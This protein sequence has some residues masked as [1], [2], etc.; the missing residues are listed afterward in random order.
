MFIFLTYVII[1]LVLI[2]IFIWIKW[3]VLNCLQSY[4]ALQEVLHARLT[5]PNLFHAILVRGQFHSIRARAV[6]KQLQPRQVVPF[7]SGNETDM[8]SPSLSPSFSVCL[9]VR[10]SYSVGFKYFLLYLRVVPWK[11]NAQ[12]RL[13]PFNFIFKKR[14]DIIVVVLFLLLLLSSSSSSSLLLL[15]SSLLLLLININMIV[16]NV[17]VAAA[18]VVVIIGL[19]VV[20]VDIITVITTTVDHHCCNYYSYNVVGIFPL[21]LLVMVVALC[22]YYHIITLINPSVLINGVIAWGSWSKDEKD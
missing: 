1:I 10:E 20:I 19:A 8:G 7:I 5:S 9:S 3:L 14:I 22:H 4:A 18:F 15:V 16:V 21:L 12:D 13:L 17:V 11:N 2:L 6:R